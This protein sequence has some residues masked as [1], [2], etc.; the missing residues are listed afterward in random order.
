MFLKA[1]KCI[2]LRLQAY[3]YIPAGIIVSRVQIP[4]FQSKFQFVQVEIS[5]SFIVL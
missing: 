1:S 5:P 2:V 4:N 3:S